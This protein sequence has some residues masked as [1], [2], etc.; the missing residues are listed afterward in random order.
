MSGLPFG[1]PLIQQLHGDLHL[2]VNELVRNSGH[3]EVKGVC[4]ATH[5]L[6]G[7]RKVGGKACPHPFRRSWLSPF[8][9]FQRQSRFPPFLSTNSWLS[10]CLPGLAASSGHGLGVHGIAFVIGNEHAAAVNGSGE[11]GRDTGEPT[12]IPLRA[13]VKADLTKEP[14][15]LT[16]AGLRQRLKDE[17]ALAG[18]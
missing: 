1:T 8:G 11:I 7:N 18:S 2:S 15:L 17:V 13:V 4:L 12:V 3:G 10:C 16:S 6:S 5:L 14:I 9:A